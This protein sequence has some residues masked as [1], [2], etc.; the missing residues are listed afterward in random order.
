MISSVFLALLALVLVAGWTDVRTR[1]I[2]NALTVGAA[3]TALLLRAL[4]GGV[5]MLVSGVLGLGIAFVL[6]VPLFAVGGMGGGDVKLL[7]AVGAFLGTERIV[8]GLLAIAMTGGVVALVMAIRHGVLVETVRRTVRLPLRFL[9]P[10]LLRPDIGGGSGRTIDTPGAL[11]IPYG[12]PIGL[13]AVVAWVLK[14]VA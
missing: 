13:G 2:P 1:R 9:L 14:G 10:E 11:T 12:V 4:E 3:A 8:L 7:A 5:P 6:A